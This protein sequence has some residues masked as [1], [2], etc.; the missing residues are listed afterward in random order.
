MDTL[1][2]FLTVMAVLSVS[3][4]RIVELVKAA[5]PSLTVTEQDPKKE[6]RR[7]AVLQ[8]LALACGTAIAY[9]A[10]A[11]IS[12][13]QGMPKNMDIG[14]AGSGLLGLLASGGSGLW[15]QALDI[16]RATKVSSE[17]VAQA[18]QAKG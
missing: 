9:L 17:S 16:A 8:I 1:T 11:Q 7:H 6:K 12:T 15:N 5:I 4:E 3:V 2:S 10:R 13:M 14:W 18:A